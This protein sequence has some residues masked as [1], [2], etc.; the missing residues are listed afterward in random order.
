MREE[1]RE[2]GA[3]ALGAAAVH[4]S[5]AAAQGHHEERG[6]GREA[7][8]L[9]AA[10]GVH[11]V[12][13][14]VVEQ[15]GQEVGPC[16]RVLGGEEPAL[17]ELLGH[18]GH[19]PVEDGAVGLAEGVVLCQG[20]D[21]AQ[22][23]A[24]GHDVLRQGV[25]VVE[26]VVPQHRAV[27]AGELLVHARL[28]DVADA[29]VGDDLVGGLGA[30]EAGEGGVVGVVELYAGA[31]GVVVGWVNYQYRVAKLGGAHL[32]EVS[33][34]SVGKQGLEQALVRF[35]HVCAGGIHGGPLARALVTEVDNGTRR[36]TW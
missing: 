4:V 14:L 31:G 9:H 5:L 34:A 21:A 12:G 10:R 33:Q 35:L 15:A 7:H 18:Q 8:Q 24:L 27:R 1:A 3:H 28:L 25:E 19:E 11:G 2:V 16:L 17:L 36:G 29:L 13:L 6:E 32:H 23:D 26:G 20:H 22:A 30:D